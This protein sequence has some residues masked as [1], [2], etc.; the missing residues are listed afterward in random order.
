MEGMTSGTPAFMAPEAAV[1]SGELDSRAD[2]YGLGC[3]A[4]WL[5]TGHLVFEGENPMAVMVQH[6]REAPLP[7]SS[8]AEVRIPPD[9]DSLVLECLA[10]SPADRP[11]TAR[12]LMDRLAA[13]DAGEP[14]TGARAA[15][16]WQKHEPALFAGRPG[17]PAGPAAPVP[18]RPDA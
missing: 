3:L 9:L 11:P 13:V 12:D 17:A 4:Y 7:P 2:L 15:A 18:P 5:L 8:R 1:G 10:K 6:A 16:W 14:W